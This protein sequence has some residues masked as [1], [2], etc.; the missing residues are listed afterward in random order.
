MKYLAIIIF[1]LF[2][3]QVVEAQVS[4]D[5][6]NVISIVDNKDGTITILYNKDGTVET[7]R[8]KDV[9]CKYKY[10]MTT[11]VQANNS[12]TLQPNNTCQ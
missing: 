10:G 11:I 4:G 6:V 8:I 9:S 7:I 3:L 12:T 5:K 1:S 2:S